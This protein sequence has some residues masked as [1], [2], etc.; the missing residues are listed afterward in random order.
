MNRNNPL[1]IRYNPNNDWLGQV[2]V[3][4]GFCVFTSEFCGMRAALIVLLS[5]RKKGLHS[6]SDIVNCWAPPCENPTQDYIDFVQYQF[7]SLGFTTTCDRPLLSD[8]NILTLTIKLSILLWSMEKY[9]NGYNEFTY[10][11]WYSF[12]NSPKI[13]KLIEERL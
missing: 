4:N 11:Q 2:S 6:I 13:Q 8:T 9:E 10:F 12:L 3:D 7:C 1:N 5:Y